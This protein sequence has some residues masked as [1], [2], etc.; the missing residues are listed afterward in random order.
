MFTKGNKLG[1]GNKGVKLIENTLR[2]AIQQDNGKRLRAGCEKLLTLF[3]KG[4]LPAF[5]AL[6]DR[7][8]G[9]A[10]QT[11]N[12]TFLKEIKELSVDEID[13]R[14][15]SIERERAALEG[16]QAQIER[17]GEPEQVH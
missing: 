10:V 17:Q 8:D 9:K 11:S 14:L 4:N 1:E 13:R 3:A 7:I 15:E 16:A 5:H 12:V 2:R 6:A